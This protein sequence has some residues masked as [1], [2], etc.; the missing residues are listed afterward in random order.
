M[1]ENQIDHE[2]NA[3]LGRVVNL[4]AEACKLEAAL[5]EAQS[6]NAVLSERVSD[7]AAELEK[8]KSDGD[9]QEPT[10]EN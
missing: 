5:V 4:T 6:A 1:N 8:L 9:E 7:L 10:Q 2:K 3:L